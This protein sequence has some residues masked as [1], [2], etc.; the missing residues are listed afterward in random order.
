MVDGAEPIVVRKEDVI[1]FAGAPRRGSKPRAGR[2]L[3]KSNAGRARYLGTRA[4]AEIGGSTAIVVDD[5]VDSHRGD[6]QIG[7]ARHPRLAP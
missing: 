3:P 7:P 2:S 6:C 4:R 1:R 5:G